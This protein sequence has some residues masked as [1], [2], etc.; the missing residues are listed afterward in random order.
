MSPWV[1]L[2][3]CLLYDPV[4]VL[5]FGWNWRARA[6]IEFSLA[7]AATSLE[8]L[9]PGSLG[10]LLQSPT[11]NQSQAGHNCTFKGDLMYSLYA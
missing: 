9:R 4:L 7:Y 2:G 1:H 5:V 11:A 10:P 8:T 6:V 3:S